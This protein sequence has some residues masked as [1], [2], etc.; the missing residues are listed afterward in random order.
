[1][2]SLFPRLIP[3]ARVYFEGF[4][5]LLRALIAHPWRLARCNY[6][7]FGLVLVNKKQL[8]GFVVYVAGHSAGTNRSFSVLDLLGSC[9]IRGCH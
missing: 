4:K 7:G 5:G 6:F 2:F 3:V 1:M 8:N 9:A